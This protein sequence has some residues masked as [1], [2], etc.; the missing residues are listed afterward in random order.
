MKIVSQRFSV[1]IALVLLSEALY[2][3]PATPLQNIRQVYVIL[4]TDDQAISRYRAN[5]MMELHLDRLQIRKNIRMIKF[6]IVKDQS[7]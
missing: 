7:A 5:Q 2:R 6:Q 3:C 1:P 4:I